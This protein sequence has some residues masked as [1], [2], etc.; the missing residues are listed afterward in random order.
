MNIEEYRNAEDFIIDSSF[1]NFVLNNSDT[2]NFWYDFIKNKP[3]L[4]VEIEKAK[5]LVLLLN[6]S[7][8]EEV[9]VNKEKELKK[10]LY[11]ID[12]KQKL[13]SLSRKLVKYAA[14]VVISI[15][16]LFFLSQLDSV[17]Y[18]TYTS[19]NT[20]ETVILNDNSEIVLNKNSS[21]QVSRLYGNFNRKLKLQ[22]EAFF[23]VSSN[24]DLKFRVLC[25]DCS[26]TVLGT[27]FNVKTQ[28]YGTG[29]SVKEGK[30]SLKSSTTDQASILTINMAAEHYDGNIEL[31]QFDINTYAWKTGEF[32]FHNNTLSSIAKLLESYYNVSFL[33]PDIHANTQL[34]F[35]VTEMG[36]NEVLGMIQNLIPQLNYTIKNNLVTI[37]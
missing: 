1:L 35:Y 14:V 17:K 10:L 27:Q 34:S 26:V 23:N 3:E 2:D 36:L 16:S 20:K 37:N 15:T 8:Q 28:K 25:R 5:Q 11:R 12:G 19:N 6:K 13:I 32:E 18:K 29:V 22:G 31:Q 21:I 4:S 9:N 24:K 7:S 33:I 30:V